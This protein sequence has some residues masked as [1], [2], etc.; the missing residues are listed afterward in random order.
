MLVEEN[1]W[2]NTFTKF[3]RWDRYFAPF[4]F[5][6]GICERCVMH[7]VACDGSLVSQ[8]LCLDINW[9]ADIH[10]KHFSNIINTVI[11]MSRQDLIGWYT[12][13]TFLLTNY[14]PVLVS[15]VEKVKTRIWTMNE[16]KAVLPT[17][18]RHKVFLPI[19]CHLSAS[20]CKYC[21]NDDGGNV[22]W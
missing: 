3:S 9:S 11:I 15:L 5:F 2:G 10:P 20:T 21:Y 1:F 17:T 7:S 19:A 6:W 8:S 14:V 4:L 22:C 13:K 16:K 18:P 12:S